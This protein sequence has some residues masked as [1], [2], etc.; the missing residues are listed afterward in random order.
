M[1]IFIAADHVGMKLKEELKGYLVGQGHEV[2]DCGNTTFDPDDDFTDFI[3]PAA[4]KVASDK[5]SI[6]IVIGRSG[7]GEQIAANKVKG[8]L[9]ALC[10][11]TEMAQLAREHNNAN[12]LALGAVF[13]DLQGALNIL[14]VFLETP[15]STNERYVRRAEKIIKYESSKTI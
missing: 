5:G 10:W 3:I 14:K 4:E 6:G 8:V 11:N 2:V 9:A 1:K 13:V 15:F 7:N 12:V